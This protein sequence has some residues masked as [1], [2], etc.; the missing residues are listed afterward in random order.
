MHRVNNLMFQGG[1]DG[2]QKFLSSS[3]NTIF[4]TPPICVCSK[5]VRK[6]V[7]AC[8]YT[9][10]GER[11]QGCNCIY[12]HICIHMYIYTYIYKYINIYMYINI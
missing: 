8:V 4:F 9:C 3:V 12:I 2:A 6:H 1:P 5:F 11:T 7:Y 10:V